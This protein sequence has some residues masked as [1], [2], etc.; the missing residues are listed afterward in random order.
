MKDN[1]SK[2]SVESNSTTKHLRLCYALEVNIN[3]IVEC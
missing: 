3:H 1:I 2:K